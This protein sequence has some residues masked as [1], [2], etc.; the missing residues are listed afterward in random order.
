MSTLALR[1]VGLSKQY[2]LGRVQDRYR[3]LRDTVAQLF[4]RRRTSTPPQPSSA[5]SGDSMIWALKDVSFEV[6]RGEVVGLI[7]RNGAGKSTLLKVLARI[8]EPTGGYADVTGRIGSLIEVGTGFHPE[9]TGRENVF[10]NG[11]ILGMKRTDMVR[12]FDQIV[13][14]A[15]V[16]Q[17]IDTPVKHYSS[18]MYLRLAFAVAAHLEPDIL[19]VDEVLAVGDV[20]FQA[21]CLA[22]M[23]EVAGQGR[24]VLF[25]SHNMSAVTELCTRAVLLDRGQ[26]AF[27]GSPTAA[28]AAYMR[29]IQREPEPDT[30]MEGACSIGA[31]RM[32]GRPELTLAAGEPFTVAVE[33]WA[34]QLRNPWMF[35][36]VEDSLGRMVMHLRVSSEDAGVRVLDGACLIELALPALWL[37]P[38]VYTAYFKFLTVVADGS[39]GRIF[40]PRVALEVRGEVEQ[41]GQALLNPSASWRV[42]TATVPAAGVR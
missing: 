29:A 1:A 5:T 41:T 27:S 2:R 26:V 6:A 37:S 19:L 34:N 24:T 30:V 18:G 11:A 39:S 31:I 15:E 35:F 22:K 21:K 40:S 12:Q 8:T 3:T 16:Q 14:F 4:V 13:E 23:G 42:A 25:V 28:V 7:G 38:G 10:L 20:A 17:F 33:L 32:N 36:I 9:L